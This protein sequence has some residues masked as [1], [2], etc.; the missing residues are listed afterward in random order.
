MNTE[1][2]PTA[3]DDKETLSILF[4]MDES[5]S[6]SVMGDEPIQGL[7][8]FYK[9]QNESGEF[10]STLCTFSTDVRFA[11]KNMKGKDVPVLTNEQYCP[12][13]MT[14]LYDAIGESV[15][16]QLEQNP[17]NV[18]VVILTD[19]EENSSQKYTKSDIKKLLN[20]ME[21]ENGWK[22]MYLGANQDSFKVADG[23]GVC[24]SANYTHT[25]EGCSGLFRRLSA[26]VSR[27]VSQ[28]VPIEKFNFDLPQDIKPD[29]GIPINPESHDDDFEILPSGPP[30][31][32]RTYSA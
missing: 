1:I 21:K 28:D 2:K 13:G 16:F 29:N 18:L 7:N 12:N 19:G 5:G 17:N 22:I 14:A 23:I 6:M 26:E 9:K 25:P 3:T 32:Q 4:I 30:S 27:C 8:D 24:S 31:L 20:K 15:K 11:H 10:M